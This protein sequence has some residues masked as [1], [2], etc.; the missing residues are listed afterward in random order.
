MNLIKY[1]KIKNMTLEKYNLYKYSLN[2][3]DFYNPY[4][5]VTRSE[6][7]YSDKTEEEL[8]CLNYYYPACLCTIRTIECFLRTAI[9]LKTKTTEN[10]SIEGQNLSQ[11]FPLIEKHWGNDINLKGEFRKINDIR[12]DILY[13]PK[14]SKLF[15][16]TWTKSN[17]SQ[18][19]LFTQ[20]I[21]NQSVI[22][23]ENYK[24]I[25][26][27]IQELKKKIISVLLS[28]IKEEFPDF[29]LRLKSYS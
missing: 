2:L 8:I 3:I 19:K 5:N 27:D 9:S 28:K 20:L 17:M 24:I 1:I 7:L 10:K 22:L 21:N 13:H 25:Y 23:D 26:I 11:L 29:T 12:N 14:G 6:F 4:T 18:K 16:Q 15:E